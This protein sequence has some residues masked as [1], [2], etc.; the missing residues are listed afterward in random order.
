[1]NPW[2][3]ILGRVALPLLSAACLVPSVLL[4]RRSLSGGLFEALGYGLLGLGLLV[5][6][7]IPLAVILSRRTGSALGSAIFFPADENARPPPVY[8]IAETRR[9]NGDYEEA[10]RLLDEIA[11]EHPR[12]LRTYILMIDIAVMNLRDP[13]RAEEACRRG[14]TALRSEDDRAT[15]LRMYEAI[16]SRL[17]APPLPG[18]IPVAADADGHV[19]RAPPT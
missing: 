11:E 13:A 19:R 7:C 12:A 17:D 10:M 3:A 15:L 8:G 9:A 1:M 18:P 14:L 5:A 6:G 16:R 2:T 4:L